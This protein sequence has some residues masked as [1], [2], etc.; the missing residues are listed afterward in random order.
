[1]PGRQVLLLC[2]LAL[3]LSACGRSGP[4]AAYHR[5]S[6]DA[7]GGTIT[8]RKGDTVWEIAQRYGVDMNRLIALNGLEAPFILQIGQRLRLPGSGY[9]RVQR[10]DTLSTIA[11]RFNTS[12][13]DLARTNGIAPP[14]MIYPDQRLRLPASAG[15]RRTAST[16][17]QP[18]YRPDARQRSKRQQS[19]EPVKHRTVAAKPGLFRWPV[20]GR[21]ISD[22]G[23]KDG[24][25]YNDGINIAAAAGTPVQAARQGRVVYAG[26][27][28]RGYGNLVLVR[29]DDGLVSAYAH[30]GDI[31]V[32]RD[33]TLAQGDII[34]TVGKSG[35]AGPPQLHFEIRR[36]SDPV[37]P[38]KYLAPGGA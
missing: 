8:V 4:P 24:G 19:P 17:Q 31:R 37:N 2:L 20:R 30:L 36:G 33:Q 9:Y 16:D 32:T 23:P 29:H 1:M 10:G 12:T 6:V 28:L 13:R 15:A 3:T 34:G 11:Q 7:A 35:I 14:Y 18:T 5:N 21:V 27:E 26:N 22:F 25:L 38:G